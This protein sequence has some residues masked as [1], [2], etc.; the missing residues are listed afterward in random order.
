M[1]TMIYNTH[2]TNDTK[3]PFRNQYFY[4][5]KPYFRKLDIR[6]IQMFMLTFYGITNVFLISKI[7][8][9]RVPPLVPW[10]H[11]MRRS[12]YDWHLRWLPLCSTTKP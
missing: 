2:H 5:Q 11:P 10:S 8:V 3:L 6:N 12:P 4:F 7:S 9:D 1:Y